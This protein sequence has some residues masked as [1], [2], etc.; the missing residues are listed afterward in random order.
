MTDNQVNEMLYEDQDD[1]IDIAN[2]RYDVS[3]QDMLYY[4]NHRSLGLS[5]AE[6]REI[7]P[8][9]DRHYDY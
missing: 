4:F 3:I 5:L 9:Y 6:A 7:D 8:N 1:L 2:E